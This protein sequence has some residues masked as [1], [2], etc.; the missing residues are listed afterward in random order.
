MV[1]EGGLHHFACLARFELEHGLKF[2]HYMALL[3]P[4][5]LAAPDPGSAVGKRSG[6]LGER[7]A[8]EESTACGL[9]DRFGLFFGTGRR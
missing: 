3:E 2:R 6:H 8:G 5:E 9:C 1:S 7:L 4:S